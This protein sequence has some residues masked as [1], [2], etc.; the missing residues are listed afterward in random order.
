MHKPIRQT[1]QF[2]MRIG[3]ISNNQYIYYSDDCENVK[4][5]GTFTKHPG[6]AHM[7]LGISNILELRRTRPFI[8]I[9]PS[10]NQNKHTEC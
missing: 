7:T 5:D 9:T 8:T 3:D 4:H 1:T 2:T 10:V 6:R